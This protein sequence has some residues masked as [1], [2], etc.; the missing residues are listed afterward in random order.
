MTRFGDLNELKTEV[1][2]WADQI[3]PNRKPQD[4]VCKLVSEAS[5]L[6]D[7][8]LNKNK[9][10]VAGE[11]GDVIILL[12]DL[13]DMYGID[14]INAGLSKMVVNRARKWT[15]EDGILRRVRE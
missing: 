7:A 8:V 15:T 1:V 2:E 3:A 13:G 4:T 5:E 6:L 11:I 12:A 10:E 14:I 9:E